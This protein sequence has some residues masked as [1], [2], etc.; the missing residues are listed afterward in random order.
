MNPCVADWEIV[1]RIAEVL[2]P[3]IILLAGAFKALRDFRHQKMIEIRSRWYEQA[4]GNLTTAGRLFRLASLPTSDSD[5]VREAVRSARPIT[6]LLL[7]AHLYA[8]KESFIAF[9]RLLKSLNDD[10]LTLNPGDIDK[11]KLDRFADEIV[12]TAHL[13]ANQF[14]R[15]LGEKKIP[16]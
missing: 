2:L 7:T 5:M 12:K 14:R 1:A 6:D 11:A 15:E 8:E 10:V 3:S 16:F 9:S 13:V 4:H